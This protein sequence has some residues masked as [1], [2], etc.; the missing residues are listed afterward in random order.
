M[1]SNFENN[2]SFQVSCRSTLSGWMIEWHWVQR[3]ES[4]CIMCSFIQV[5]N[6]LSIHSFVTFMTFTELF[7]PNLSWI[8]FKSFVLLLFYITFSRPRPRFVVLSTFCLEAAPNWKG[9]V[10]IRPCQDQAFR[11]GCPLPST[12]GRDTFSLFL[13]MLYGEWTEFGMS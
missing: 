13:V 2:T 9:L 6:F 5:I 7:L 8:L 10:F 3:A 4:P 1:S 12:I 11:F